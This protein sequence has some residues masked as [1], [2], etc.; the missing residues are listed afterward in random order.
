[1]GNYCTIAQPMNNPM[2]TTY[3]FHDR[4]TGR[5]E[6]CDGE[7]HPFQAIDADALVPDMVE[8]MDGP[9]PTDA[10][11]RPFTQLNRDM[12]DDV[13]YDHME[14]YCEAE[15]LKLVELNHD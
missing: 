13:I 6:L 14:A 12:Q 1:M 4:K 10:K 11:M 7:G 15:N 9:D 5:I 2:K 3:A 8:V